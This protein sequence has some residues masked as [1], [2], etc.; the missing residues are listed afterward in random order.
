MFFLFDMLGWLLYIS[1]VL[2]TGYELLWMAFNFM[3][4]LWVDNSSVLVV[5]VRI[6]YFETGSALYLYGVG[7]GL[8]GMIC[9]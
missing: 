3:L 1:R 5:L 9:V 2:P 7:S 6:T 4:F 8:C